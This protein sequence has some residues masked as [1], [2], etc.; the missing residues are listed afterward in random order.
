MLTTMLDLY[1]HH[2]PEDTTTTALLVLGVLKAAAVLKVVRQKAFNSYPLAFYSPLVGRLFQFKFVVIDTLS[3]P[4]IPSLWFYSL[5]ADNKRIQR[6]L[7]RYM[8]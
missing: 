8:Y 3:H 6:S 4:S 2:P 7:Y 1:N 5:V